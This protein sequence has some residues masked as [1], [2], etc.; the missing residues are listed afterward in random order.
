MDKKRRTALAAIERVEKYMADGSCTV[1]YLPNPARHEM[2][3]KLLAEA[4]EILKQRR[5]KEVN[6]PMLQAL[7]RDLY[8]EFRIADVKLILEVATALEIELEERTAQRYVKEATQ[9]S[10]T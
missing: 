1:F 3:E 10:D 4:K 9:T 8:E 6:H 5:S 7:A 2:L